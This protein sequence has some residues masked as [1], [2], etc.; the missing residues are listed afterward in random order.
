MSL[1]GSIGK[2]FSKI[3]KSIINAIKKLLSALGPFLPLLIIAAFVL[4]PYIAPWL[5]SMGFTTAS[6]VFGTLAGITTTFGPWGALAVGLGTSFLL[7]PEQTSEL[8]TQVGEVAG[9]VLG[10]IGSAVGEGTSSLLSSL[11]SGNFLL[12]AAIGFGIYLYVT[13]DEEDSSSSRLEANDINKGV[14]FKGG[15]SNGA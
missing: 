11:F 14:V 7:A 15:S 3:F 5:S 10:S 12:Y 4:A 6:G 8:I 9:D 1:F 2:F 13:R